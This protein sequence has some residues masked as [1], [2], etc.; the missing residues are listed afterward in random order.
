MFQYFLTVCNILSKFRFEFIHKTIEIN[1][2]KSAKYLQ[3]KLPKTAA[4]IINIKTIHV[5]IQK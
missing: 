5:T 3:K 4:K 1:T 2:F